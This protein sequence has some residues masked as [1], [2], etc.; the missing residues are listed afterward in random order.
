MQ[1]EAG[2][3]LNAAIAIAMV[4]LTAAALLQWA[5][6]GAAVNNCRTANGYISG[7]GFT[8]DFWVAPENAVG[9]AVA[10]VRK[11]ILVER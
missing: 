10:F 7:M 5:P 2:F 4:M 9:R 6:A 8:P 1:K 11:H 3:K